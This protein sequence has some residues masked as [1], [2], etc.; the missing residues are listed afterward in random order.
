MPSGLA[1]LTA[2][3]AAWRQVGPGARTNG[4]MRAQRVTKLDDRSA[5]GK[6]LSPHLT[7]AFQQVIGHRVGEG[8]VWLAA[9]TMTA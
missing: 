1:W 4:S 5:A 3:R 9:D 6:Y 7:L 8:H 2:S